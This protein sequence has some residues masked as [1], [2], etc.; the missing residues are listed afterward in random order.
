MPRSHRPSD[1]IAARPPPI[2][3]LE[4]SAPGD[5][6]AHAAA[7]RSASARAI[8][9]RAS[10][11]PTLLAALYFHE[12]RYDPADPQWPERDRFVLS[13]GHYSIALWAAFAEAGIIPVD[14]LATYGA[15]ESRLDMSTLDTTP[16]V[17]MI[18]GSLGHGLGQAVGMAL[19][20]RLNKSR[21]ARLLSNSRTASC[22]R[23]RPGRRRWRRA[24]F[25]PRQ[26]RR[27]DR[28]QRHPGRRRDRHR[29]RAG[30]R[31]VPRLRLGDGRD[32]RQRHGRDRH[33]AAW[34]AQ[35]QR[36][37]EGDRAAHL[38]GPGRADARAARERAFRPRRAARMGRASSA[39]WRRAMSERA[40]SR[41]HA[42]Q[43]ARRR[44]PAR[45]RRSK[46]RSARR[47]AALGT[48]RPDVVGLTAD[49]GKYTDILP[50]R[51]AFPERFFNVG[52]AEQN[53][54]AVV[55]GTRQDRPHRLLHDLR[56]VR[57]AARLRFHRHRLRA[58]RA[59]VKIFAGLPG[60]TT[61]YGGTHQA[62]EDLGADAHDPGAHRDRSLRRDRDRA[63]DATRSRR[64]EGPT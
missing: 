16:G 14:E 46:R 63:G 36:Q 29:H 37:A 25:R 17:E 50:F 12:L 30:R 35:A 51:D 13:T 11:S 44:R 15:D 48:Q 41:P 53:L 23:A 28:L 60:L 39:S 38:A 42:R 52:M 2:A 18:G 34:R 31:Q 32:R 59:N 62:I 45:G 55:G 56:R 5:A 22:R 58:F 26:P 27:A 47:S 64:I 24:Q 19:G 61:G 54:I 20:L 4:R 33:G 8:S 6:P 43:W 57:D 7:W 10:A 49:L 21:G 1:A 3:F 9:A 40:G